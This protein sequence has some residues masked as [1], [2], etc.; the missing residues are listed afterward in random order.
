MNARR[1]VREVFGFFFS[2]ARRTGK[3][4]VFALL[5]LVPVALAVVVR[6]VLHGRTGDMAAVF[7]EILM[8]FFLQFYIVILALFY[9]TSVAAEEVE[10]RTLSY[11][12]TRPLPKPA[13]VLGK[14]AAYSVLMFLMVGLSLGISYFTMNAGQLGEPA[15]Y[16]RFA[17]YLGVLGLGILAY[18]AFFTFLGTILKK[19]ILVGLVFGFGWENVIQYF[20]GSTQ[21]FSVVHYLKSMLP[22][23]PMGGGGRGV[24]LLLFRLEPTPPVL[25]V[26]MLA[27]IA[28][29]FLALACWLFR[30]KEYLYEE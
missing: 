3:T 28:G 22:Y 17:G 4:R 5:A 15:L 11:L 29:A 14:Y 19:A 6:V 9:G 24:A 8:V 26:A 10:G 25:A 18:A 12:I 30:T 16:S 23:R 27:V 21:R 1:A 13:I 7:T 20:P 2:L